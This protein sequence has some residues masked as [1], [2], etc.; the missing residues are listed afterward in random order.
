MDLDY[1]KQRR[2]RDIMNH[3]NCDFNLESLYKMKENATI[4]YTAGGR[5]TL[6]IAEIDTIT[7]TLKME[8]ST[9]II[10]WQL[11]LDKLMEVHNRIHCGE[12]EFNYKDID[13]AIPTWGNYVTGLLQH[14]VC[15]KDIE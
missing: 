6:K 8:R 13:K 2:Y 15:G 1:E 5:K 3:G 7:G 10:T 11:R 9:G 4:F 12:L 14:F